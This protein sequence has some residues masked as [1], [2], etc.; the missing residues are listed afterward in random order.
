MAV[1]ESFTDAEI[2]K[3]HVQN[4]LDIDAPGQPA[5]SRRRQAQLLGNELLMRTGFRRLGQCPIER[6]DRLLKQWRWRA[7]V[8]MPVSTVEK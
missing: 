7:R 1:N 6:R 8:T 5:E 2:A 3:D 4:I